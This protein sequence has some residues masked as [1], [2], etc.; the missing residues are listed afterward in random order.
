MSAFKHSEGSK[1]IVVSEL[2]KSKT[3]RRTGT[4]FEPTKS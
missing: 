2:N 4:G 1:L 3:G